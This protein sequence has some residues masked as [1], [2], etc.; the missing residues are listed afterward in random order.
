GGP[1]RARCERWIAELGLG[2]GLRITGYR[3]D[4]GRILR[5]ADLFLLPS[6]EDPFPLAALQAALA[7][8]PIVCFEAAGGV[9][10]LVAQGCGTAVA[11]MDAGAMAEAVIAYAADP[12]RRGAEGA[13]GR[14]LVLGS[15]TVE[16]IGPEL[17]R[18]IE[19][20]AGSAA[21]ARAEARP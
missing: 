9:P 17:L 21:P 2:D 11:H 10:E 15:Y 12:A 3:G 14:E 1:D 6:E 7:R 5:G 13:R 18:H 19:E 16:A 4:L 20:A 8:L